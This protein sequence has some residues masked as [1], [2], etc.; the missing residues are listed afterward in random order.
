VLVLRVTPASIAHT[1]GVV[2]GMVL[3]RVNEMIIGRALRRD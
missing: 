3:V 1:A 2:P